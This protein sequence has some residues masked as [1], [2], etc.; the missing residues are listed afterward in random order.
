MAAIASQNAPA[1]SPSSKRPPLRTSIEAAAFAITA[2]GRSGRFATSGTSPM[3][4][5]RPARYA[6]SA[7]VSRKRRW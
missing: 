6:S 3:R 7:Q 2:G 1:P 4:S 5:V